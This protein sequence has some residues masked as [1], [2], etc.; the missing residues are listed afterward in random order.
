MGDEDFKEGM[1]PKGEK[2]SLWRTVE[3]RAIK[4]DKIRFRRYMFSVRLKRS[5]MEKKNCNYNPNSVIEKAFCVLMRQE[6][7]SML[8]NR[9]TPTPEAY[10]KVLDKV[11]VLFFDYVCNNDSIHTRAKETSYQANWSLGGFL[12]DFTRMFYQS[13]ENGRVK[14]DYEMRVFFASEYLYHFYSETQMV[15]DAHEDEAAIIFALTPSSVREAKAWALSRVRAL[16]FGNLRGASGK[17]VRLARGYVEALYSTRP[18][19][20]RVL[21]DMKGFI[22]E[23][24]VGRFVVHYQ[25]I[26]LDFPSIDDVLDKVPLGFKGVIR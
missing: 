13:C 17:L 8:K 3:R 21:D 19:L 12:K 18:L 16:N 23:E 2:T 4:R 1:M 14:A 7:L 25:G 22:G 24:S 11:Y 10:F 5:L 20:A 6:L 15:A 26:N 9:I